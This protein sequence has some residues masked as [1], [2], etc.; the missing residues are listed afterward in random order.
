MEVTLAIIRQR[1]KGII[2]KNFMETSSES[3][4]WI[5]LFW[6][7]LTGRNVVIHNVT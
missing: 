1:R 5:E 3:I 2:E 4:C 6:I 7:W